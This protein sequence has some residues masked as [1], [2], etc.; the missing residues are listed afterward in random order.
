MNAQLVCRVRPGRT[1][2]FRLSGDEAIVGRERGLAVTVPADGISR[3]HAKIS[4]DGK[5]HWI[6]NLSPA[7]T[8]LNGRL[9]RRERLRHLDV[10][11]L[12]RSLELL[13]LIRDE[14]QGLV[15]REGITRA[16]LL[17]EGGE[18]AYEI[19]MGEATLGRSAANNVVV[20]G[21]PVSKI[22]ARLERTSLQLVVNDLGSANG[23]FVN[24]ARVM[25]ALLQDGD[26]L[27]LANVVSFRVVVERGVVGTTEARSV[28][29]APEPNDERPRFSPQ[30]K[31]RYTWDSGEFKEIAALQARLER[32]EEERKKDRTFVRDAPRKGAK[33]EAGDKAA[34]KP[35]PA[36][37]AGA[38]GPPVA[39]KPAATPPAAAPTASAKPAAKPVTAPPVAAAPAPRPPA[40]IVEVSLVSPKETTLK[41]SEPGSYDIGRAVD[42]PL[43]IED[44]TVSRRHSRLVL[45]A[46]RATVRI[47]HLGGRNGTQVNGEVITQ[48]R[49][50]AEGDLVV[51]G[52]VELTVRLKRG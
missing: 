46:D 36:A 29:A 10:V 16:A 11:S 42:A 37:A 5:Q 31:T 50:L 18:A 32:E 7:G 6:Q 3:R 45:S 28:L 49:E 44:N 19:L 12:G 48:P 27:S 40:P 25:T 2:S 13:F 35:K 51:L 38:T 34:A 23:T 30:W 22:H 8:F 4:F 21:G 1:E 39:P 14:A 52:E 24:G 17:P 33:P 20:E 26:L 47:E 15:T 9:V 41:L 43:R